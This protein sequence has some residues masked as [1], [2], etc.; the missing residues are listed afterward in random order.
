M[1][2]CISIKAVHSKNYNSN[3]DDVMKDDSLKLKR[4]KESDFRDVKSNYE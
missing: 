2:S 1:G 4:R 3:F